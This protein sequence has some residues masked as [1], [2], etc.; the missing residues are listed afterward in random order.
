MRI[1]D[2]VRRKGINEFGLG[3]IVRQRVSRSGWWVLFP[4]HDTPVALM[5]GSLEVV[6]QSSK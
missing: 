1:G 2:L 5:E 4:Y 6:C 3:I